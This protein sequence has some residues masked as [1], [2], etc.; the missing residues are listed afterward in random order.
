MNSP[1]TKMCFFFLLRT[2]G[3]CSSSSNHYSHEWERE[4][5]N[6]LLVRSLSRSGTHFLALVLIIQM[7]SYKSFLPLPTFSSCS[8]LNGGI[9]S[10]S[11]NG[12]LI[13]SHFLRQKMEASQPASYELSE[14]ASEVSPK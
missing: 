13:P 11:R 12:L 10:L 9:F 7:T 14:P 2:K 5:R 1:P 4:K 6:M 8:D 3:K